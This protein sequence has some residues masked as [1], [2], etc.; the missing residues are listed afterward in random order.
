MEATSP[1]L[2][3]GISYGD[4][5]CL[6][7]VGH[8]IAL[9][10]YG[11]SRG[12][13]DSAGGTG[14]GR[15]ECPF[16]GEADFLLWDSGMSEETDS[17]HIDLFLHQAILLGEQSFHATFGIPRVTSPTFK[18]LLC[19]FYAIGGRIAILMSIQV[20]KASHM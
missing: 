5:S 13:G 11:T 7:L 20:A 15:V 10:K 8:A 9:E 1:E 6:L 4:G 14:R 3:I 17:G 2:F 18:C 12:C 19:L 16:M